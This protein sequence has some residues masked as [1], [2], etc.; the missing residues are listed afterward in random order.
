[1]KKIAQVGT[2]G[3][4]T[5]YSEECLFK[6]ECANHISAGDF[7][8]DGFDFS[9]DEFAFSPELRIVPITEGS[10]PCLEVYCDTAECNPIY[11][12]YRTVPVSYDQLNKG[13]VYWDET[14]HKLRRHTR[15]RYGQR[16]RVEH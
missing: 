8:P 15:W 2:L 9:P 7:S 12:K 3:G 16:D 14:T 13:T 6:K 1:M 10:M 5:C 11:E 4:I